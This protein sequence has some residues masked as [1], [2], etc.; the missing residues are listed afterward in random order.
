[1]EVILEKK[2]SLKKLAEGYK[3]YPQVLVNVRVED[4]IEAQKNE[5][6]LEA[7]KLATEKIG[8]GRILLRASGTEPVVR[9]MAEGESEEK[10]HACINDIIDVM[11]AEKL[12]ID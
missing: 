6:V 10:C 4:K 1:M 12:V 5:K 2:Q 3:T 11:K 9:V 8:D 7:V